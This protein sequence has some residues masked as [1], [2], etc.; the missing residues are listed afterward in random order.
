MSLIVQKFGGSS[1]ADAEGVKRVAAASWTLR[2]QVTMWSS[3][4]PLW[5]TPPMSCSTLPQRVTSNVVPSRELDMLLTAGERISTAVLSMAINDLG[6]KA[7]SFTGSQAGMITDGVHGSAR[8]VEVR[9]DRIRESVEAGNIAIVAGFQG[10]NRQSGDITTL[11]R[12]G[13]DTTAVAL[14]AALNARC[15]RDLLGRGRRIHRRP[16]HR[17]DRAQAGYHHQRG[18]AGDGGERCKDSAPA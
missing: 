9:P 10:M 4:C 11:G 8:L 17:A 6:A 7:Q 14:A 13:S 3:W 16:A 12:G 15:V 5:V 18:N 1:V 2:R